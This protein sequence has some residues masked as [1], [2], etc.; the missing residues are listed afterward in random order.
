MAQAF[1]A[2]ADLLSKFP[3]KHFNTPHVFTLILW[4][5]RI[6]KGFLASPTQNKGS[7]WDHF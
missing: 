7:T 2:K 3:S 1:C 4:G 5:K 6:F